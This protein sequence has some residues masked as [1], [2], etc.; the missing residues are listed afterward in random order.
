[1]Q[2][3]EHRIT[4][5]QSRGVRELDGVPATAHAPWPGPSN[6][7]SVG[8]WL[9]CGHSLSVDP[10]GPGG[11]SVEVQ[12]GS[13]AQLLREA[14]DELGKDAEQTVHRTTDDTYYVHR[15][16]ASGTANRFGLHAVSDNVWEWCRDVYSP[17]EIA[18]RIGDGLRGPDS[19]FGDHVYRGGASSR[20]VRALRFPRAWPVSL[21]LVTLASAREGRPPLTPDHFTSPVAAVGSRRRAGPGWAIRSCAV[22]P[23]A[24]ARHPVVVASR[25]H[26][27]S[28]N[29]RVP[30]PSV[31][32]TECSRRRPAS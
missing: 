23:A 5:E 8:V 30:P 19:A 18:P 7:G 25:R 13:G 27:G 9:S 29:P 31:L 1:M 12:H 6:R 11:A 22:A 16:V 2:V 20:P 24:F 32:V 17:Y 3:A 14:F 21:R 15:P 26:H 4:L 28:P 10:N